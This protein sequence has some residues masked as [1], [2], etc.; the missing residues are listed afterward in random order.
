MSLNDS[1]F[2]LD[3]KSS[4][5]RNKSDSFVFASISCEKWDWWPF[6][7][8]REFACVHDDAKKGMVAV[9]SRSVSRSVA[10]DFVCQ[11]VI[12]KSFRSCKHGERRSAMQVGY[13]LLRGLKFWPKIGQMLGI[14]VKL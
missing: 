3:F 7:V 5:G 8:G 6:A 9:I 14:F 13:F 2:I 4:N 1:E 12:S 11:S 10:G